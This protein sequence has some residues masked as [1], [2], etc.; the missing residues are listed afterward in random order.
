MPACSGVRQ[1]RPT[2]QALLPLQ[3]RRNLEAILI[4]DF[5]MRRKFLKLLFMGLIT[6]GSSYFIDWVWS[7]DQINI[8]M[9]NYVRENREVAARVGN[10]E[11][12]TLR[13]KLSAGRGGLLIGYIHTI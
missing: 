5:K 2:E 3:Y 4:G 8:E 9:Q 1:L 13:K 7:G 11:G 12:I 6:V 10:V